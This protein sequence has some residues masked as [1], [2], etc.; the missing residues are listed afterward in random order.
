VNVAHANRRMHRKRLDRDGTS[1]PGS[2][3]SPAG[4]RE[5]ERHLAHPTLRRQ[6]TQPRARITEFGKMNW[7]RI[8]CGGVASGL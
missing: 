3:N 7:Q 1:F 2:H 6:K 4:L 5:L 8:Y